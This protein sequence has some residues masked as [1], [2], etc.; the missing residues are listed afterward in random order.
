MNRGYLGSRIVDAQL[1]F[2]IHNFNIKFV[3]EKKNCAFATN[4][5]DIERNRIIGDITYLI[6]IKRI[7]S[8]IHTYY[9]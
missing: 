4:N 1:R 7:E 6:L 2:L 5:K 8:Q 9:K 3:T